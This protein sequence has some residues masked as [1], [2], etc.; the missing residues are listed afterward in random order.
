MEDAELKKALADM[1][2][3]FNEFKKTNDEQIKNLEKKGSESGELKEKIEKLNKKMDE[4][5]A[6]KTRIEGIETVM[7]RTGSG[8]KILNAKGE[9]MPADWIETKKQ[10]NDFLRKGINSDG[11][12]TKEFSMEKKSMSVLSDPDGG[13]TVHADMSGQIVKKVYESSPVR[14]VARVVTISTDSLE[15]IIDTGEMGSGWVSEAGTR[16]A[17]T[18]KQ[19][20]KWIIPVHEMYAFPQ[21]TQ[22]LLDDS[23]FNIEQE[24]SNGCADKFARDEATAFVSGSGVGKPRGFLTYASGTTQS[25]VE[26]INA[27]SVSAFLPDGLLSLVYALKEPYRTRAKFGFTRAG[28][29]SLR[30]IKGTQNDHYMWQPG[31]SAGQPSSLL[32]YPVIEMADLAT[33]TSASLSAVF[34]DWQEFYTIV[35]RIGIRVLRDPYSNKPYVGF[36]TTKR[37]GGAVTNGEAGKIQIMST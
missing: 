31:L 8:V 4:C 15:G 29:Q 1:G 37:V 20:G 35:D 28:I 16:S 23:S 36:Y 19:Y 30:K 13:Y 14:T 3:A 24:V 21:V 10:Y 12:E 5:E 18:T 34:A 26:Q 27:G 25:T 2:S 7:K 11:R 9:E 32:G 17:T 6:V 22:K 33:I